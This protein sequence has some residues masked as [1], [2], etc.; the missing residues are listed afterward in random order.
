MMMK[1][2]KNWKTCFA[3]SVRCCDFH[4]ECDYHRIH[5]DLTSFIPLSPPPSSSYLS[6]SLSRSNFF[7]HISSQ[8]ISAAVPSIWLCPMCATLCYSTWW[9]LPYW[10]PQHTHT[11]THTWCGPDD[12]VKYALKRRRRKKSLFCCCCCCCCAKLMALVRHILN[13]EHD[14]NKTKTNNNNNNRKGSEYPY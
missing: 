3:V 7:L 5:L 8:K 14:R 10:L 6:L 1:I 2:R 11:H 12:K 4:S 9:L 13:S